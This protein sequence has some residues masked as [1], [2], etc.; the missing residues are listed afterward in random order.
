MREEVERLCAEAKSER[1]RAVVVPSSRVAEAYE[2]VE[3]SEVKVSC[4]IGFPLGWSD[5][6]AKRF[7]IEVAVD[8]GAHE[9][10]YVPSLARLKERQYAAVLRELRDAADACDERPLKVLIE[11]SL[12]AEAELEE[13]VKIVL[14]SGAKFV[15][16]GLT[17]SLETI[18][19]VRKIA[20][21][22]FGVK[23]DLPSL[24]LAQAA[25]ESGADL[26][27]LARL[28]RPPAKSQGFGI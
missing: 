1:Y 8:S 27:S 26:V 9:I 11:A 5:P 17:G 15:S 19:R 7:E 28:A 12:W 23:C 6:D 3:G 21:E 14:D 24:E 20:G 25:L 2:A 4:L 18:E 16:T 22:S 13:V 10:E